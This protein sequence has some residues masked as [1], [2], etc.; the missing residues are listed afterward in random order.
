MITTT[1]FGTPLRIK[2]I[3]LVNMAGLWAIAAWLEHLWHPEWGLS[4]LL[5]V[6]FGAMLLMM[7]AFGHAAAHIFSAR[8]AG[9]PM[10]EIYISAGSPLTLYSDNEVAPAV[11]IGRS[12]GGPI[13]SAAGFLLSL[14]VQQL[15]IPGSV[16][17]DLAAWSLIGQ[18]LIL[19]GSLMPM[20]M[21]D[22]G[23]LLKWTLV[24]QGRTEA[25][26]DRVVKLAGR[27]TGVVLALAV[28]V[29][30]ALWRGWLG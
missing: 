12:L 5:L 9:G 22:G 24:R 23:V 21:V 17:G 6:G 14:L 7:L 18:G 19:F 27:V 20:P 11:H 28:L 2:P 13:Y 29:V 26:A 10:S 4:L 1:I 16:I 8:R 15:A 25:A 3:V 30:I